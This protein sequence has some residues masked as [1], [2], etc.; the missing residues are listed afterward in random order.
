MSFCD[1]LI[2]IMNPVGRL[3][4]GLFSLYTSLPFLTHRCGGHFGAR[5]MADFFVLLDSH[6]VDP[7]KAPTPQA[8]KFFVNPR[9]F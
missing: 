9:D 5:G 2:L 4:G 6:V 7:S 1:I 3:Q 8:E